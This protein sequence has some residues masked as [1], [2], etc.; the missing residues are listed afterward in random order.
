MLMLALSL[1]WTDRLVQAQDT[2]QISGTVIARAANAH[3][4][5]CY[6]APALPAGTYE[7]RVEVQGFRTA[8]REAVDQA[9]SVGA[10]MLSSLFQ[11]PV[12]PA[13]D[14]G[15]IVNNVEGGYDDE[16]L[17]RDRSGIPDIPGELGSIN[18]VMRSESDVFHGSTYFFYRDPIWPP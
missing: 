8:I 4:E 11:C 6:S 14:R 9:A 1:G 7:V 5:G 16:L 10:F 12:P 15:S 3:A 13:E 2:G 17:Q 18:I